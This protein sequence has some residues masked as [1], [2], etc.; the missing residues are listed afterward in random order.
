MASVTA[1]PQPPVWISQQL[2][3]SSNEHQ[4][5]CINLNKDLKKLLNKNTNINE[6]KWMKILFSYTLVTVRAAVKEFRSGEITAY[7]C[8]LP[9]ATVATV[10]RVQAAS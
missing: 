2:T 6:S 8:F 10:T 4:Q 7:R 5:R 1:I 9:P 3:S